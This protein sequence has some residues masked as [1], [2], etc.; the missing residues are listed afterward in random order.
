MRKI[1]EIIL[2]AA[3]HVNRHLFIKTPAIL[4]RLPSLVIFS[5]KLILISEKELN[6]NTRV[7]IFTILYLMWRTTLFSPRQQTLKMKH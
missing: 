7:F 2:V 4:L 5:Q 6:N 1:F 3:Q